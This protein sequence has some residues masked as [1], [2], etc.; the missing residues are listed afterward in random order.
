MFLQFLPGNIGILLLPEGTTS[1]KNQP[2][3]G[4]GA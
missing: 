3:Q 2:G 4:K 1:D